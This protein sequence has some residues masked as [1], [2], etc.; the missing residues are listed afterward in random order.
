MAG[1][2]APRVAGF[3]RSGPEQCCGRGGRECGGPCQKVPAP[4]VGYGISPCEVMVEVPGLPAGRRGRASRVGFPRRT[5]RV[6]RVRGRQRE[7]AAVLPRNTNRER[8]PPPTN[9]P[10]GGVTVGG[11][12]RVRTVWPGLS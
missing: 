4:G 12:G 6:P 3:G 1:A 5:R 10:L 7:A 2:I 8:L 9:G 11:V